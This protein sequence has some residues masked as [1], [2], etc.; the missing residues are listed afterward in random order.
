[1]HC[2]ETTKL[3]EK[4]GTSTFLWFLSHKTIIQITGVSPVAQKDDQ[5]F[6]Q[7]PALPPL[8]ESLAA[9]GGTQAELSEKRIRK[10]VQMIGGNAENVIRLEEKVGP[11]GRR[12]VLTAFCLGSGGRRLAGVWNEGRAGVLLMLACGKRKCQGFLFPGSKAARTGQQALSQENR[13]PSSKTN[14]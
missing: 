10:S 11:A 8:Q 13:S 9:K 5:S 2:T 3:K 1:M 6:A 14:D 4:G 12:L 7:S